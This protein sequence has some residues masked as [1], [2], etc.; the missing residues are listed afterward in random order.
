MGSHLASVRLICGDRKTGLTGDLFESGPRPE[1]RATS[2]LLFVTI[3]L[4][5]HCVIVT[6]TNKSDIYTILLIGA[7]LDYRCSS[8]DNF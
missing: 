5:L 7:P 6:S 4:I 8:F 1:M 2:K 3:N